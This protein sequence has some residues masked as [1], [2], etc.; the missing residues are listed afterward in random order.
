MD[1]LE[2]SFQRVA[3]QAGAHIMGAKENAEVVLL[4]NMRGRDKAFNEVVGFRGLRWQ[5]LQQ[6]PPTVAQKSRKK[7]KSR[8]FPVL[9]YVTRLCQKFMNPI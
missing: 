6:C 9:F 1:K 7:M 3:G 8:S 2:L 4:E 5:H